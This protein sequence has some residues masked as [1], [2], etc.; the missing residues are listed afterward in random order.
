MGK[1][2]ERG[3]CLVSDEGVDGVD[4]W[5]IG[6]DLVDA[7]SCLT[8]SIHRPSTHVAQQEEMEARRQFM[9]EQILTPEAKERLSR[10]GT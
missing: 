7:S 5:S 1:G 10:I 3:A 6:S 8:L 4:G 2:G 9:L